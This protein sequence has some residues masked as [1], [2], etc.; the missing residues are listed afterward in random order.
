MRIPLYIEFSGKKVLIIG[1]GGVGTARAK[2]FREAGAE[3]RVLSLEFSKELIKLSKDE[4]V[5]L[6]KGDAFNRNLLENLISWCD[7][8]TVAIGDLKIN[9]TVIKLARKYKALVNLANDAERT[10]VVVP[11]EGE[12]NGIRFAVTTEGKSGVVA[13]RVRDLFMETLKEDS[14]SLYLLEAMH[15]LKK[16][17]KSK[18]VPVQLRMKLYFVI[19]ADE[20]FRNLVNKGKV[21][22]ARK[23]AEKLVEEYVSG[24]REI[25]ESLVKIQF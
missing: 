11:F 20:E 23:L 17:M 5:E 7:L 3:I 4:N 22:E 21:N 19:S 1:G 18:D 15:Y 13:R 6:I 2:K 24:E 25:D 16:Y 10:E 8:V 12:V 9:D 14:E